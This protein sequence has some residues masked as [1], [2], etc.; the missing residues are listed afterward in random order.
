[1]K[2]LWFA[3]VMVAAFGSLY[4]FDFDLSGPPE[5]VLRALL[6]S[7]D[8]RLSR[9]DVVG[10]F[11]LFLPIGLIGMLALDGR[12][13][14]LARFVRVSAACAALALV[15]QLIQLYLP[16]RNASLLD[17]VWNTAGTVAGASLASL[18][19]RG[20]APAVTL[21]GGAALAPLA[22]ICAWLAYRLVPFVPSIDLQLF[23]D[24]LKPLV[25]G[26]LDPEGCVRDAVGW[27]V[28]AYLLRQAWQ[29]ARKDLFLP[30]IMALV[31]GLEVLI[32]SNAVDRADALGATIA[33][34]LWFGFLA[35]LQ[36]PEGFIVALIAGTI[37]LSGLAPF[38][39][40]PEAAP[41]DWVPFRGFLGGSMYINAQSALEK[42]FLYGGL[43][44]VIH[45]ASGVS[46]L[47]VAI[48]A[49]FVALVE[50]AQTRVAGHY[51]EITDPLLVIL[52]SLAL[53]ALQRH[54]S[55]R[56]LPRADGQAHTWKSASRP[57]SPQRGQTPRA[58]GWV[59][60]AVSMGPAQ[61]D[62][63]GRLAEEWGV[64]VS[65]A[66]RRIIAASVEESSTSD[67]RAEAAEPAPTDGPTR[68]LVTETVN[69]QGDHFEA[70][71]QIA[72]DS[73]RSVAILTCSMIDEYLA[74][75]RGEDGAS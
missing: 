44:F 14:P 11:I 36:R 62:Q 15:L 51:P 31:F 53:V 8:P 56:A 18:A 32:V 68:G 58:V 20:Q 55:A 23:K 45:R 72:H 71:L 34:L 26:P 19:Q 1:M 17:V 22:L 50:F 39:P 33:V 52:A 65:G 7:E 46:A 13:G 25:Y 74:G 63:L 59:K 75:P 43:V 27:I 5:G 12:L 35:R 37:A 54:D 42:S 61:R 29:G 6:D 4:P 21:L 3:F 40:Q 30:A 10:N 64:S 66:A 70:L 16:S 73:G 47:G 9:G 2:S 41:F 57:A 24:S 28:I 60:L 38:T 48:A 69:L 49:L 67:R